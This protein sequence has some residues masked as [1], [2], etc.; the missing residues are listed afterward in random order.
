MEGKGERR[1]RIRLDREHYRD[2]HVFSLTIPTHDRYS[3]FARY[4]DVAAEVQRVLSSTA[5]ERNSE[6]FAWCIMPEHLHVLIQDA[7]VVDFVR[8]IKGRVV[9]RARR[10]EPTRRLWQRS[11]FD[12]A[13][14]SEESLGHVACYI[15]ENPVRAG[16]VERAIDYRWSGSLVWRQWR[17][18]LWVTNND[19]A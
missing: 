5:K 16:I 15:F 14:R 18:H 10:M 12:H 1:K 4:A 8:L 17:E 11:F 7:D 13:L 3:W 19:A 6:L 9:P 2:G